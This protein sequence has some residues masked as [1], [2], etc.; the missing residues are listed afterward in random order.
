MQIKTESSLLLH[1]TLHWQEGLYVNDLGEAWNSLSSVWHDI[2]CD[3]RWITCLFSCSISW[4]GILKSW[5]ISFNTVKVHCVTQF[6][7]YANLGVEGKT[8]LEEWTIKGECKVEKNQNCCK[9]NN[10][11]QPIPWNVSQRKRFQQSSDLTFN[12]CH[13]KRCSLSIFLHINW[14]SL[15]QESAKKQQQHDKSK[16]EK[17]DRHERGKRK[18]G[19]DSFPCPLGYE[20]DMSCD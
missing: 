16:R 19:W 1:P 9:C 6:R 3:M 5:V 4:C 14:M 2:T 12:K 18:G 17:T 13:V 8:H 15:R 11:P 20:P 7:N 10:S